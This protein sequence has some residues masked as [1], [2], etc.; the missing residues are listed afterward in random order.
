[1]IPL[2]L[3][4]LISQRAIS[5][6]ERANLD[7]IKQFEEKQGWSL[8]NEHREVLLWS[9]GLELD[10]G[11]DRLMGIDSSV[12]IDSVAWNDYECWKFAWKSACLEY[13]CFWENC[14]GDQY[15]Y[16]LR[17]LL[18]GN[19]P[20]VYWFHGLDMKVELVAQSFAEFLEG[21]IERSLN[22][23]RYH[24]WFDL[25]VKERFGTLGPQTNLA[26]VPPIG[27]LE[28][29]Q[30]FE[31][32]KVTTMPARAAMICNGDAWVQ[33]MEAPA[34][35]VAASFDTYVDEKRRTRLRILWK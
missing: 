17:D 16:A 32:D 13:W 24:D 9:N 1:M 23:T 22:Y 15:A 29:W 2:L 20:F 8:P 26:Y 25:K 21:K 30:L 19:P 11:Y 31:L 10:D 33:F 34:N 3:E 12:S 27:F 14:W 5:V 28:S 7:A 6:H 35:A 18:E 4:P